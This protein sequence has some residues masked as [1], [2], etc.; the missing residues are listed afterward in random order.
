MTKSF[1]K[2]INATIRQI[3]ETGSQAF[4]NE[5]FPEM[6]QQ[7]GLALGAEYTLIGTL[8]KENPGWVETLGFCRGEER[9]DNVSYC[10][11]GTPCVRV[12]DRGVCHFPENVAELFPHDTLLN[13]LGVQGYVGVPLHDSKSNVIGIMVALFVEPIQDEE[14]SSSV[15]LVFAQRTSAEIE[16]LAMEADRRALE[17]QILH[18]QKLESLGVLAGGI[19]HDFNN[20]LCGILGSADLA[21]RRVDPQH[22][23]QHNLEM[24]ITTAQ[25]A[26]DLCRQLLAYSGKGRF[27]IETLDVTTTIEE[28]GDLLDMSVSKN[29]TVVRAL[30]GDIPA[31]EAD[32]TQL[33]QIIFNLVINGSEAIGNEPGTITIA[34]GSMHCTT[35]YLSTTYFDNP[36]EDGDYVFIEVA[37]TGCGMDASTQKQIFDPFFTTKFTGRGLGLA[38]TLGI[39]RGHKGSIKVYSEVGRGTTFKVLFPVSAQQTRSEKLSLEWEEAWQGKGTVLFI[40]DD[41]FVQEVGKMILEDLGFSVI[42]A[43]D[44][45][46]GIEMFKDQEDD[47]CLVLMDMTM[48]RMSGEETFRELRLIKPDVKVILTSG[49]NEQHTT[50][51]FVGKGL[52]G[53]V[54]KPFRL[55]QLKDCIRRVLAAV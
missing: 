34:T 46:D 10:L 15:M 49:F 4:G 44:G 41:A 3:L 20:L 8:S 55:A 38:A 33:R 26:S 36:E 51:R 35:K 23:A 27:A 28:M 13:D 39:I 54:P 45:I 48:P 29:V 52:A 14:F 19:A 25:R 24:I 53:F 17:S 7:L 22:V 12:M 18:T 11:E 5:F 43:N 6:A 30:A 42:C 21:A 32:A 2:N 16:R 47:I 1:E 37:D 50:N 31:I 40:E 9:L